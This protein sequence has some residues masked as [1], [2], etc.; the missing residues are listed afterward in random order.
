MEH[1]VPVMII[2]DCLLRSYANE[3]EVEL[4]GVFAKFVAGKHRAFL[5]WYMGSYASWHCFLPP[6]LAA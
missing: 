4:L 3:M 2:T 6:K 1:P 5:A